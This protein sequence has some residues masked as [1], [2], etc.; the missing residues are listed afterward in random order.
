MLRKFLKNKKAQNTA[1]YAIMFGLVVAGV[2]AMS[3]Y[4]QRALQARTRGATKYME[5]KTSE[6]QGGLQYEPYYLSSNYLTSSNST[7]TQSLGKGVTAQDV[8]DDRRRG[9]GGFQKSTF[10]V[11][12]IDDDTMY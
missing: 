10:N 8:Q 2:I 11:D 5:Q 1:E 12:N 6:L 3:T 9:S 7:D 4:T